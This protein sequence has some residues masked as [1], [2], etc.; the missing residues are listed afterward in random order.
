MSILTDKIMRHIAP[1]ANDMLDMRSVVMGLFGQT[2]PEVRS[3]LGDLHRNYASASAVLRNRTEDVAVVWLGNAGSI[4]INRTVYT[5][6]NCH[7]HS[8]AE[9]TLNGIKYELEIH[10]VHRSAQNQIAVVAILYRYGSPDPFIDRLFGSLKNLTTEDRPLGSVNP[11]SIDFPGRNYYRY[12]G[13]LTT[14]PCSE[15][16]VWTVF[17]QVKTVSHSQV[18][19]LKRVLPPQNRNNARPTQPLNGRPVLLYDPPRRGN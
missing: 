4:T 19:A 1:K 3:Q 18:D 14:P 6:D 10:I 16:V 11:E 8:P 2:G 15:G 5:V 12:K 7:W 13:S 9:H 17:Q